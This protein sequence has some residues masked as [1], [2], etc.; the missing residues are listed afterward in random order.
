MVDNEYLVDFVRQGAAVLIRH[1][2]VDILLLLL[3]LHFEPQPAV[4]VDVT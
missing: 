4:V 2:D 1:L 3:A